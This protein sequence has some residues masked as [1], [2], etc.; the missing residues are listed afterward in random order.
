MFFLIEYDRPKGRIVTFTTFKDSKRFGAEKSRLDLELD[1]NRKGVDHEVVI[2]EAKSEEALR[3]THRRYFEDA[4]Q[5]AMSASE[6]VS[7]S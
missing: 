7:R 6:P 1:L 3:R 2:L 5:I 4:R